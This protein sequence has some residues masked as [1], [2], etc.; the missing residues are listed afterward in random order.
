MALQAGTKV[1]PYEVVAALGRGGMG[2]VYRARDTRLGR[3]V[4]LKVLPD[5][6][7]GDAER[8]ARFEREAQVLASLNHPHIA[9]I[10]GFE[11]GG[12]PT[13]A[14]ALELVEGPT[15]A[16][17]IAQGP[18]LFDEAWPIA[19]QI[20]QALE[21]AHDQGIIHRDLKP[22]NVKVRDDGT[23]KVL[24]F[25]LA[26]AM[27]PPGGEA[28]LSQ[29]PTITTPAMT[30]AGVLLGTAAYMSP[31]VAK[32]RPADKRADIW[33]FGCLLYELLSGRP[34]FDGNDM[35]EVL[36]AI[37]R[38][39]PDW[40][41]LPRSTPAGVVTVIKRCLQKDPSLRLRDIA[42]VRLQLDDALASPALSPQP[43]AS[44]LVRLGSAG[45]IVAAVATIAAAIIIASSVGRAPTDSPETRLQIATPPTSDPLSFAIAPDGRSV[46]FDAQQNGRSQLW[47]RSLESEEALPLTGTEGGRSPFWSPDSASIGFFAGGM[48]K[49]VDLTGGFVR[50]LASAP[51]FRRGAWTLDGT[52]VFGASVGPLS[53]VSAQGGAVKEATRLLPGQTNH[54]IP[55]F[56]PDG[57][58][59]L[60]LTLG[61]PDV[62]GVYLGSLTDTSIR[63]VFDRESA[64]AFMSPAHV[65]IVR[66][67]ALWARTFD[68]ADASLGSDLLPVA[69]RVLVSPS[70]TGFA[71]LSVSSVGAIAYRASAGETQ[72]VWLDRTGNA[73][74]SVG[75]RDDAQLWLAALSSDGR[76]VAMVRTVD[77]N[78][79]VWLLESQRGAPRR[80]TFDPRSDA[81][82][83]FSP[84]G[85]RIAYVSDRKVDVWDIFERR[86][87]GTGGETLLLESDENKQALGW[88]PDGRY[89]LYSTQNP[90]TDYDLWVLPLDGGLKPFP[91]AATP[92]VENEARF[93]P[94]GRWVAF[95]ST[96]TGQTEI[97]HQPFPGPGPKTQIS[98]GGG[99]APRWRLDGRE[100]FYVGSENRLM[101]VSIVQ[102]SS[103]LE[104]GPPRALFTLSAA[105]SYEPSPDGQR[106]L[107]TTV[108]SEASPITLILNWRPLK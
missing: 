61:T 64:Y 94:D 1:G 27:A 54:R 91:I 49:R 56:L 75:Q 8:L 79:D 83:I 62:R 104:A 48:L 60:L 95:D 26:K 84:D 51:N 92:Y 96:E 25:G 103:G 42:D 93:S 106:F 45:W 108:V 18:L 32:G 28:A 74:D 46:V 73:V 71:A 70:T 55:Q 5:S 12:G 90:Q 14:L 6:F 15:L 105:A 40:H 16:D 98:V 37:V 31:E 50:N 107:V 23:V 21:A 17:R 86:A 65:L 34:A 52:I 13:K 2:E 99:S 3:D 10:Y 47:L 58:R 30:R 7:A 44:V 82:P 9:A 69:P 63:R 35:T 24:D 85:S 4:A 19:R 87:D 67:G 102:G 68:S 36:G 78:T 66:E 88:S 43:T 80:L 76:T 20:T 11:D 38:L 39:E 41:A 100:L 89:I 22:A 57:Q 101:A 72:L 77:G 29:S 97:Y 81:T 59:F 33:A 53:S